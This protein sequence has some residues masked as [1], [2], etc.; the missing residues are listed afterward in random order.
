MAITIILSPKIMHLGNW[1][2]WRVSD[3][4]VDGGGGGGGFGLA[5]SETGKIKY[6]R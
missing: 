3:F 1:N 6:V 5:A 2:P 4:A